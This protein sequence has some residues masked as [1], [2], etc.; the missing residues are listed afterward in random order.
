[1]NCQDIARILDERGVDH[2]LSGHQDDVQAHLATCRDCT[3]D[4]QIHAELSKAAIPA[5]PA[6]LRAHFAAPLAGGLNPGVR[7]R[8]RFV[9]IGAVVAVAAAAGM[10]ALQM[11][12]SPAPGPEAS[13]TDPIESAEQGEPS[14]TP[15]YGRTAASPA[16]PPADDESK[17][18]EAWTQRVANWLAIRDDPDALLTAALL[19]QSRDAAQK[20]QLLRRAATLAPDS[21]RIQATA[22]VLCYAPCDSIPYEQ[23]LRRLAPD[24]AL[25]WVGEASR[26]YRADDRQALQ[27]AL[28]TMS[29]ARTFDTYWGATMLA[30]T[31]QMRA[32]LVPPPDI[33]EHV[34]AM[35]AI[36]AFTAMPI[37][38]YQPVTKTCKAAVDEGTL[39]ECRRIGAAMRAGDTNITNAV[40]FTLSGHGLPADSAEARSLAQ[41]SIRFRWIEARASDAFEPPGDP[42]GYLAA[43]VDHPREIDALRAYL[44]ARG[45]PTEPP[46][47]WKPRGQ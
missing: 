21:A 10:L 28:T 12:R 6:E 34:P 41:E 33:Q 3:R 15:A 8:S 11:N 37:P 23:A 32:A 16:E 14:M 46:A 47:G 36:A 25:G 2:L 45:I 44:E 20:E 26:A 35:A 30:M 38:A 24:N 29:R 39:L 19:L 4:W 43:F 7:R 18:M 9:V 13:A 1:M 17:E 22:L 40:G 42:E 31:S 27:R 5:V